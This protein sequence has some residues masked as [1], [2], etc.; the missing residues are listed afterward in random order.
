MTKNAKNTFFSFA[1]CS[2]VANYLQKTLTPI[3]QH[4]NKLETLKNKVSTK[5][6]NKE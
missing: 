6:K 5:L 2:Q 1:T 3:F 4:K